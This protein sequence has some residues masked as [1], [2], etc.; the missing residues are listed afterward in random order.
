[1]RHYFSLKP[2][3]PCV[4][5]EVIHLLVNYCCVQIHCES[6]VI[7]REIPQ[8]FE[9]VESCYKQSLDTQFKLNTAG[10]VDVTFLKKKNIVSGILPKPLSPPLVSKD[11]NK[12]LRW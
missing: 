12:L 7:L 9:P 11:F 3:L 1:M 6:S 10:F 4:L 8:R 2:K 5:P